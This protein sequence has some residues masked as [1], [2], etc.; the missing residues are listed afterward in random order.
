MRIRS[1]R[2]LWLAALP[3]LA[4]LWLFASRAPASTNAFR[5]VV[6]EVDTPIAPNSV[7]ELAD[8]LGYYAREGVHVE[9]LHVQGTPIAVA[10]L[11]AG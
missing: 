1:T 7:I 6:T 9:L 2:H 5:I 4:V 3:L 10:A 8:R 11:S